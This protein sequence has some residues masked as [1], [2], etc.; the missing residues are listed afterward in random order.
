MGRFVE[1]AG[2]NSLSASATALSQLTDKLS[3]RVLYAFTNDMVLFD[4]RTTLL[5][6][7]S[8]D[9]PVIGDGDDGDEVNTH[10]VKFVQRLL[11][12]L[13]LRF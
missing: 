5:E 6:V 4:E 12:T 10:D 8:S 7:G 2:L 3:L 11:L 9:A 13:M 1:L